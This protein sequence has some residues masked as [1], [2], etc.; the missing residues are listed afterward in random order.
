MSDRATLLLTHGLR[1]AGDRRFE[2]ALR[3]LTGREESLIA[4]CP[5]RFTPAE[6]TSALIAAVTRLGS[7]PG[8]ITPDMAADLVVGDRERLLLK[9]CGMTFGRTLDLVAICPVEGCGA[10]SE[11]PVDLGDID[12]GPGAQADAPHEIHPSTAEGA[13]TVRFRLPS[14]RDQERF[15]RAPPP[16]AT[17]ALITGCIVEVSDPSG[18]AVPPVDLPAAFETALSEAFQR[19]DPAAESTTSIV[20]PACRTESTAL[21]DGFSILHACLGGAAGLDIDVYRMAHAYHWSEADI[22]AL[23]RDRRRRYLAVA[24]AMEEARA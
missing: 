14:G 13:W 24:A 20:C 8:D 10:M 12:P 15:A 7:V 22:L 5:A 18:A 23:P 17:R 6:C 16:D 11:V 3:G 2:A 4:S 19:L 21:L 9:L 1:V